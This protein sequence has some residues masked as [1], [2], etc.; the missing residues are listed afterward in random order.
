MKI[1]DIKKQMLEYRDFYG[2]ELLNV[3]DVEAAKT[4]Q[5][6]YD[7]LNQHEAFMESMLSDAMSHMSNFKHKIELNIV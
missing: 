5:E 6:L 2:G 4:R 1:D 3:S 7:I